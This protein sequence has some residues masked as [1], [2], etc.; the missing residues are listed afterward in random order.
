VD[1]RADIFS[2]GVMLYVALTGSLPREVG[3]RAAGV[4]A[5]RDSE[6]DPPLPSS[7]LT[8]LDGPKPL[9]E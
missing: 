7:R 6:E 2:L 5:R 8:S 1:T 9:A 4:R 3:A